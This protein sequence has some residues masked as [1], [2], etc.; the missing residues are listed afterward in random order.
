M[1]AGRHQT[2]GDVRLVQFP[3]PGREHAMPRDGRASWRRGDAAHRRT[4][5]S[6]RGTYRYG[7]SENDQRG[8]VAF[9]GEW[10]GAVDVVTDLDPVPGGPRWLG[11][12]DPS[13]TPPDFGEDTPPQNTDPYVWGDTM[14]YTFCRQPR[15]R[16]LRSLGRGS[17]I[18]FGSSVQGEFVLDT[19]FVV[20]GW[21]EHRARS[22]LE[23]RTDA[24]HMLATIGPMYGWGEGK[25]TYRLYVG[26]TPDNP[27]DGMF[28]F[29]PCRPGSGA[30]AGFA[31]PAL[32]VDGVINPNARMQARTLDVGEPGTWAAW[33]AAV[34]ATVSEGLALATKL[35]FA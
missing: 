32:K 27:V 2:S 26:A 4:F 34:E 18:L 1:N 6:S 8:D 9:W 5:L 23:G 33:T 3:H 15:N 24:T 10:E 19:V 22:D 20:A 28:S 25:R 31:R 21:T 7:A 14:R 11:R 17:V 35:A 30:D 13:A 29:V 12:P 16:K